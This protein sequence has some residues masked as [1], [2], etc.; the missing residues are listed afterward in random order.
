[1]QLKKKKNL[2]IYKTLITVYNIEEILQLLFD[3]F[4]LQ[5]L[6]PFSYNHL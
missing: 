3:Y 1:M 2:F 4:P 6:K 5:D